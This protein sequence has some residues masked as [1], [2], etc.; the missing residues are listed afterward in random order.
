[1]PTATGVD[2]TGMDAKVT[3]PKEVICTKIELTDRDNHTGRL[4]TEELNTAGLNTKEQV[5]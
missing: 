4:I 3:L 5:P 1:M 2:C